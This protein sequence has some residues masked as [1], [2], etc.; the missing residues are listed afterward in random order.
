MS[1]CTIKIKCL[2]TMPFEQFQSFHC[3]VMFLPKVDGLRVIFTH[4]EP[5]PFFLFYLRCAL[6]NFVETLFFS[7]GLNC[8][9]KLPAELKQFANL[10]TFKQKLKAYLS[11]RVL[12]SLSGFDYGLPMHKI[13]VL[14]I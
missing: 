2:F 9:N 11:R 12:Y 14:L 8:F 1:C 5:L 7:Q 10:Q 4:F 13:S 6:S 3:I